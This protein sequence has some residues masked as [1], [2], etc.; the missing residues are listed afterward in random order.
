MVKLLIT[1]Y[2]HSGTSML[3][4][5]LRAHPQVGWIEFEESYIE[6]DKPKE[7]ILMLAKKRVP[8]LSE[9]VWGEKIPWGRQ[10]DKDAKRVIAFSKKWLKFFGKNARILHILRHPFDVASSGTP[11][12]YREDDTIKNILND[13]PLYVDFIN[14]YSRCSTIVYEE[15]V[16]KPEIYLSKIFHF[17]DINVTDKIISRVINTE[18]KFGKI[19]AD[20]AY[21]HKK[22]GIDSG[23]DYDEIIKGIKNRL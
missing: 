22:A 1:G 7:W 6:Y 8:N 13:I 12:D 18:L 3:M 15:L 16:S 19:N 14:K 23:I 11:D 21:A 5:L 10:D 2:R 9:N 20:R 4:S 17:L